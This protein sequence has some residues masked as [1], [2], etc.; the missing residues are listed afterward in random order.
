MSTA[1]VSTFF[2]Q[3]TSEDEQGLLNA[4]GILLASKLF[5]TFKINEIFTFSAEDL[6]TY[7]INSEEGFHILERLL[8]AAE[9]LSPA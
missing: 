7:L 1:A 2:P 3:L 6:T 9:A 8:D 5:N 4:A